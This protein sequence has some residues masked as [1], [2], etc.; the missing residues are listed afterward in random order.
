MLCT[1][2]AKL[3]WKH[4]VY[5]GRDKGGEIGD[6]EA[7]EVRG[8][9]GKRCLEARRER[10]FKWSERS[11]QARVSHNECVLQTRLLWPQAWWVGRS[12]GTGYKL[13]SSEG[14]RAEDVGC[15]V[16]GDGRT[17]PVCTDAALFGLEKKASLEFR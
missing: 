10:S 8:Q 4:G 15:R 3:C 13:P 1:A 17:G 9:P 7:G 5:R 14:I 12:R 6:W 2:R 16:L 11:D